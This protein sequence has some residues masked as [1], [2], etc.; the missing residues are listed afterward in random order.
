M[1]T[2]KGCHQFWNRSNRTLTSKYD[3]FHLIGMKEP[4]PHPSL[5]YSCNP[6]TM[7]NTPHRKN[8]ILLQRLYEY[9]G[10]VDA[11]QN[12]EAYGKEFYQAA[13]KCSKL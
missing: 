1:A 4:P 3:T 2:P 9:L 8:K 5:S 6:N 10:N 7:I 13:S 12:P 11:L